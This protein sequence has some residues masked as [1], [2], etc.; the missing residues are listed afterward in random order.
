VQSTE[1]LVQLESGRTISVVQAQPA[2]SIGQR[3]QVV[4]SASGVT[5]LVP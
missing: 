2:F 3:V 1:W 4:Q 5:R